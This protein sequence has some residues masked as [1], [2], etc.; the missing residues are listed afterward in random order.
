MPMKKEEGEEEVCNGGSLYDNG[1]STTVSVTGGRWYLNTALPTTCGGIIKR[2]NVS[3]PCA[4]STGVMV[5]MWRHE[6]GTIY[7]KV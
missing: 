7:R 4:S 6:A 5:A 2:Y 3:S 1:S